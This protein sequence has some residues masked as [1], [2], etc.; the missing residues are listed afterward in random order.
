ME[1]Y[2]LDKNK[3]YLIATGTTWIKA[4]GLEDYSKLSKMLHKNIQ[5]ILNVFLMYK[6]YD[7]LKRVL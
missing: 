6:V 5:L 7:T 4:K 3:L 2:N 1:K